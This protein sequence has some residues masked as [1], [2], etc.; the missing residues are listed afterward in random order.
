MPCC[1][2]RRSHIS[3]IESAEFTTESGAELTGHLIRS[4]AD[5]DE[6][7]S[8]SDNR[9]SHRLEIDF[10]TVNIACLAAELGLGL[11]RSL[12]SVRLLSF[13]MTTG[14]ISVNLK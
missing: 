2:H 3:E 5:N 12:G 6:D 8:S 11:S 1:V 10:V 9:Q 13:C 14:F 4:H 7:Q